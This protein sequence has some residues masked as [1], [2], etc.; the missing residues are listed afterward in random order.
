MD[1]GTGRRHG[2]DG[3]RI[4]SPPRLSGL[5]RSM[6]SVLRSDDF[7][8]CFVG[9]SYGWYIALYLGTRCQSRWLY[10]VYMFP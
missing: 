9:S 1:G 7:L 8:S 10:E 6:F 3:I 2:M 4:W 5:F